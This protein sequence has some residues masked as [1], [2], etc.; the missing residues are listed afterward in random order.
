MFNFALVLWAPGEFSHSH[1]FRPRNDCLFIHPGRCCYQ[2]FIVVCIEECLLFIADIDHLV[3]FCPNK[4]T[5][6]TYCQSRASRDPSQVTVLVHFNIWLKSFRVFVN[7]PSAIYCHY[8]NV[9]RSA[10]PT[11]CNAVC[12]QNYWKYH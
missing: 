4:S 8:I 5:L 1:C 9:Y 7:N 2:S 3:G 12:S 11:L 6:T 10:L